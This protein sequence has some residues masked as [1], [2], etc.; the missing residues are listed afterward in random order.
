MNLTEQEI[1]AIEREAEEWA[2]KRLETCTTPDK[3]PSSITGYIDG[4][5]QERIKAKALIEAL[6]KIAFVDMSQSPT[7]KMFEDR[8][9]AK[10]AINSYNTKQIEP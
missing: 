5:T 9:T 3:F 8:A 10:E 2:F 4:A 6:E 7:D 1:K